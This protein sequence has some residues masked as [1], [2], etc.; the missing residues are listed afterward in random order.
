MLVELM[1][2]S[3]VI[4][5][6]NTDV[7]VFHHDGIVR[8]VM[9]VSGIVAIQSAQGF[10][11]QYRT[12]V[13]CEPMVTLADVLVAEEHEYYLDDELDHLVCRIS[14]NRCPPT[15]KGRMP[16]GAPMRDQKQAA[17]LVLTAIEDAILA[18]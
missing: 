3:G 18:F 7:V 9:Q 17:D 14:E 11:G 5:Q 16:K 12:L 6:P 10:P 15:S 1:T 4:P 2:T 8:A 13:S